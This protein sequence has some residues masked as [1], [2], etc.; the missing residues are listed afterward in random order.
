MKQ[1]YVIVIITL[2]SCSSA[3]P[4]VT[5]ASVFQNHP[6]PIKV[7]GIGN[8]KPGYSV[9]TLIDANSSYFV[10]I[11]RTNDTLHKEAIYNPNY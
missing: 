5:D 2:V 10:V 4:I 7:F 9:Y 3:K 1:I 6:K 11:T 8:W